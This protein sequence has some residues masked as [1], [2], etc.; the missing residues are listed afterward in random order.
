M[1]TQEI[2]LD[3]NRKMANA[4][5]G[6][7]LNNCIDR[8]NGY[9]EA[10]NVYYVIRELLITCQIGM[11]EIYDGLEI[12]K[13]RLCDYSTSSEL[14]VSDVVTKESE[15]TTTWLTVHKLLKKYNG[16]S[17]SVSI[18]DGNDELYYCSDINRLYE[19]IDIELALSHVADY[20]EVGEDVI[21]ILEPK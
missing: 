13:I 19:D 14:V 8:N 12:K 1:T 10:L 16:K 5:I 11:G 15:T 17:V 18:Y 2:K 4:I 21:I 20:K 7:I 9:S 6:D 3:L